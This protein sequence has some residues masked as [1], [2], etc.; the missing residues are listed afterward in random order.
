MANVGGIDRLL[1]ILIGAA[2]VG[3][4]AVGPWSEMLSPWGYIG[5]IPLV[6][7]LIGYCPAYPLI[8]LNTA[9]KS[10]ESAG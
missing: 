4:T 1:R 8:G 6:T 10:G 9:K 5:L 2:L 7:G 3:V